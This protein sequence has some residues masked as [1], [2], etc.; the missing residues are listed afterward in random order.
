[1]TETEPPVVVVD[2]TEFNK[3]MQALQLTMKNMEEKLT[4]APDPDSLLEAA[5]G[6]APKTMQF[7]YRKSIMERLILWEKTIDDKNEF[8]DSEFNRFRAKDIAERVYDEETREYSYVLNEAAVDGLND[9]IKETIGELDPDCC[10]PEIWADDIQRTHVYPGSIFLNAWFINWNRSVL[11][12]PGDRVHWCRVGPA[13]CHDL[14][15][16]EPTSTAPTVDCPYASIVSRGCSLYICADDLEDVQVG[17][18]DAV[19]ASLGSC[20]QVCVDNYFFDTALSCT[21]AGTYTHTGRMTGSLIAEAM[22]SM[23]AGTYEPVKFITHSVPYKHLMQ[24]D[25]FVNACTFGNRDVIASGVIKNYLGVEINE[26]PKGTL[27]VGGGTYRSL[28]LAKGALAGALK[29]GITVE[30]E[31]SPRQRR[32]WVIASMRWGAVC[33]HNDGIY[34]I[35]SVE[36]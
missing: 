5:S 25:Q 27:V 3:T 34:W 12:K 10:I 32:R 26:T 18:V 36:T 14:A 1:M 15:C 7:D 13:V 35:L 19:N 28:L 29:R 30:T 20:L 9:D 33:L 22:G 17:L 31:Y 2:L 21:N 23:Q 4:A 11:N 8:R 6:A 16:E 24:D